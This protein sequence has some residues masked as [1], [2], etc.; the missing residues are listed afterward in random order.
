MIY[1]SNYKNCNTNIYKTISISGDRGKKENY[2]KE[3]FPLLAPKLSFWITWH[4]NIN[5][6]DELENNKFYIKEYYEQVLSKLD[7]K[8]IF[9]LLDNSIILC[10]EDYNEFCHRHIVAEWLELTLNIKVN[11]IKIKNNYIIKL[12]RPEY[13]KPILEEIIKEDNNLKIIKK[14]R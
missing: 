11:E 12:K 4:N 9:E 7:P 5:T 1:T 10:Y 2:D 3:Y 6:I 14:I 13:I 8:E